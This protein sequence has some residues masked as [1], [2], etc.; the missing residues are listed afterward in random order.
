[1][2]HRVH[3]RL[4]PKRG[5]R[6]LCLGLSAFAAL[7]LCGCR[8]LPK[9]GQPAV[10]RPG[11]SLDSSHLS[12][13]EE[14]EHLIQAHARFAAGLVEELN[15]APETALGHYLAAIHHD[16]GNEELTLDVTRKLIELRRFDDAL[17][18]LQKSSARPDAS[19]QVWAWLG[20]VH[21]LQGHPDLAQTAHQ[22]AI[23]RT[24]RNITSYR[25]LAQIYLEA[26]QIPD[27]IL[28]L[29][30]ASRQPESDTRF[31]L[32]L[33]DALG[34]LQQ[35]KDPTVGDLKPRILALLERA[36][37]LQPTEPAEILRLADLLQLFGEGSKSLPLYQRLLES[38]PDLPG[39]RER[40]AEVYLRTDNKDKAAEQLRILAARKPT[41]PLPHYYL[42]VLALESKRYDEAVS[43]FNQ[44]LILRP[45]NE[46]I[47]YDLA[48]ANLSHNRPNEAL[49]VL[50]RA[51]KKF[52]DSFQLEFYS[53]VA[54]S[55]LKRYEDAIRSYT[56]AEV[57]A[58]ATAPEQLTHLFYFQSGVA[59]ER[60]KRYDDAAVQFE[61][62]VELKPDFADALN[63]LGYMWA[64]RGTN[65]ERARELIQKA[66]DLEPDNGAFLDSLAWVLYQLNRSAEAL[67]LQ[68]R[69]IE[70]VKEPDGT[71]QDHLGDIYFKL[72]RTEEARKAWQRSLEIEPKPEVEQ[73]LRPSAP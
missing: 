50:A 4:P 27:A 17:A 69:A 49:E 67:P 48:L 54:F 60:A 13:T 41:N 5:K 40:L 55:E 71:L 32:L 25:S 12:L 44:V 57:I 1:V 16:P 9:P 46:A 36:L 66:V 34:A 59:Y 43:A 19:G 61:K 37:A 15:N 31:L 47:H 11:Q 58:G 72:G 62:S 18:I 20:T 28:V 26:G 73:K 63:Y 53:A 33:A 24:P 7:A 3:H 14:D 8:S 42:G 30:E 65:L 52:R 21:K 2:A 6:L 64:E 23:R 51:R 45:D 29:E 35:L 56:A 10:L 38:D 70:L 22:E 68:L 39:L